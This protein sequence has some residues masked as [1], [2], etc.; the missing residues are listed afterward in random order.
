MSIGMHF[1]TSAF[2]FA[3]VCYLR[4]RQ[5]AFLS[6]DTQIRDK[7]A[8]AVLPGLWIDPR[9]PL[10][11]LGRKQSDSSARHIAVL[12]ACGGKG[13]APAHFSIFL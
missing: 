9:F 13:I 8:T 7:S 12:D 1:T 2:C 11:K 10:F 6:I 3:N 4:P 5:A